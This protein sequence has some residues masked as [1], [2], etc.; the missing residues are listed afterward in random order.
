MNRGEIR[1]EVRRMVQD[2]DT[3]TTRQRWS[4]TVL[5]SR[6]DQAHERI[7]ALTKC[8]TARQTDDIVSGTQEYAVP[9]TCLEVTN[10]MWL[11]TNSVL[12]SLTKM[13]ESEL[14]SANPTWRADTSS[15]PTTYYR[16]GNYIGVYPKPDYD[17]TG[18]LV[19]DYISRPTSLTSD[20]SIP[21]GALYD[22]YPFHDC[23]AYMVAEQCKFDELKFTEA[24][25]ISQILAIKVREMKY[26][27][28]AEPEGARMVNIYETARSSPRRTR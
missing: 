15:T 25:A 17:R 19:Y 9:Q 14:N 4:D 3:D 26:H 1:D 5:D 23:I 12:T 7:V 6:I 18:G 11:D 16:R 13:T 2:T 28:T 20:N 22:L 8:V 10:V 24:Q 27:V 21:Y